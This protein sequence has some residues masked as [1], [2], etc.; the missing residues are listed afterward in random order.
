MRQVG[1]V[2]REVPPDAV[3]VGDRQTRGGW[4]LPRTKWRNPFKKGRHGTRDEVVAKDRPRIVQQPELMAALPE[5]RGKDLACWFAPDDVTGMCCWNWPTQRNER[6]AAPALRSI[7]VTAPATFAARMH[8]PPG[9]TRVAMWLK[10]NVKMRFSFEHRPPGSTR[11]AIY[12]S[13]RDRLR[14]ISN[15][16]QNRRCSRGNRRFFWSGTARKRL[17]VLFQE[18][19][20]GLLRLAERPYTYRSSAGERSLLST[21]SLI[22]LCR[23]PITGNHWQGKKY[24]SVC[25]TTRRAQPAS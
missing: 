17:A 13:Y 25:V 4:N 24:A 9:S 6:P 20:G 23:S 21:T 16:D 7:S 11:F 3:C 15:F 10:K 12:R 5:L 2:P 14:K 1:N 8:Q 19:A 22:S 18:L